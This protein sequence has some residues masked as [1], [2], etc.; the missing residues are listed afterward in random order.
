MCQAQHVGLGGGRGWQPAGAACWA[1]PY[2]APY[3]QSK[4]A[5]ADFLHGTEIVYK[6]LA[7]M[8]TDCPSSE[9]LVSLETPRG[10]LLVV[11][12]AGDRGRDK[13]NR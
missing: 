7:A 4:K 12:R 10:C 13:R 2:R 1:R 8:H 5:P 3:G 6:C 11:M 9:K